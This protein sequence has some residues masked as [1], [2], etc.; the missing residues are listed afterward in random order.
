MSYYSG[1]LKVVG[2]DRLCFPA[3]PV[4][5]EPLRDSVYDAWAWDEP[6]AHEVISAAEWNL[7]RN[8]M[9]EIERRRR[10]NLEPTGP[11][12]RKE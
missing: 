4:T 5:L 6:D 9:R 7:R 2:E 12:G 11:T 8:A 3:D 1:K 10:P